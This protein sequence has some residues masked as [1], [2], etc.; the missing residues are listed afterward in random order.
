MSGVSACAEPV[1]RALSPPAVL[2]PVLCHGVGTPITIISQFH[3]QPACALLP[4]GLSRRSTWPVNQPSPA[5]AFSRNIK[6]NEL[7]P[8]T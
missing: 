4:T 1:E 6:K 2:P 8:G 7:G 3:T 5:F